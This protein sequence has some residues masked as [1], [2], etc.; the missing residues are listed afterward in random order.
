V[1]SVVILKV[2]DMIIGLRV[3]QEVERDG[4]DLAIHGEVVP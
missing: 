3:E 2:V 4:L 1:A